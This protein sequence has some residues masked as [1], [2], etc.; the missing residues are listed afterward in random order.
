MDTESMRG[1]AGAERRTFAITCDE[2]HFIG[3]NLLAGL[4]GTMLR[5]IRVFHRQ[6]F[7]HQ[8]PDIVAKAVRAQFALKVAG[9]D[10]A[11]PS[12]RS[13]SYRELNFSIDA[14]FKG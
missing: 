3:M 12:V 6:I 11:D 5:L 13:M 7:E 1:L 14:L 4:S 8:R 9:R 2:F 10:V